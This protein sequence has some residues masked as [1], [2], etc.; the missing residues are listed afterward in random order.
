MVSVVNLFFLDD[1][2]MHA[3]AQQ[4][5]EAGYRFV[6]PFEDPVLL[7]D[8]CVVGWVSHEFLLQYAGE[9]VDRTV[10]LTAPQVVQVPKEFMRLRHIVLVGDDQDAEVIARTAERL[11]SCFVDTKTPESRG[12]LSPTEVGSCSSI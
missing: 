1:H 10:H 9:T 8:E 6:D 3:L 4:L 2:Q 12:F 11:K 7:P 5:G